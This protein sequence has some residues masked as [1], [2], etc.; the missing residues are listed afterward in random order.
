MISGIEL[1]GLIKNS[2]LFFHL[3][4]LVQ[5][6]SD[7]INFIQ[8]KLFSIAVTYWM[9]YRNL[10]PFKRFQSNTDPSGS[11]SFFHVDISNV[12]KQENPFFH[13]FYYNNKFWHQHYHSLLFKPSVQIKYLIFWYR[14]DNE[15][16]DIYFIINSLN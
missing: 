2:C 13:F 1:T 10:D 3:F 12:L 16:I 15:Q 5:M 8:Y 11:F 7:P 14:G 6:W 9:W 4:N